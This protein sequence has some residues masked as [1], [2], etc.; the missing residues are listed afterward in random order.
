MNPA[1]V[2][3]AITVSGVLIVLAILLSDPV[4]AHLGHPRAPRPGTPGRWFASAEGLP[5]TARRGDLTQEIKRIET[6]PDTPTLLSKRE[7]R[8]IEDA[9]YAGFFA[10]Y[11]AAMAKEIERFNEDLE[12]VRRTLKAWHPSVHDCPHCQNRCACPDGH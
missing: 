2:T 8:E 3:F 7:E 5:E 12:P 11:D 6:D 10:E 9:A 1:S 4:R